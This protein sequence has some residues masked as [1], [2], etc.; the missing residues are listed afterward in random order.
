MQDSCCDKTKR[1]SMS[2]LILIVIG[3]LFLA[4][5]FNVELTRYLPLVI[6]ILLVGYGIRALITCNKK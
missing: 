2:G 6:G 3:V 1:T 4:S 5:Y